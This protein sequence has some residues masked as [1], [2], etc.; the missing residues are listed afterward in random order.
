MGL[1]KRKVGFQ[2]RLFLVAVACIWSV[3]LSFAYL[4]YQQQ[5][6]FREEV[7]INNVSLALGNII[8]ALNNDAMDVQSYMNFIR[9]YVKDTTLDDISIGIYD[10][11]TGRLLY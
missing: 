2:L 5:T 7:L 9:R 6:K 11:A 10:R 8:E 4:I 3:I 1:F